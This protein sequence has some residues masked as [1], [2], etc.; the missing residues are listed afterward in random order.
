MPRVDL[1]QRDERFRFL[2]VGA[3]NTVFGYLAYVAL[4]G[5]LKDELHY[6]IVGLLSHAIS[7]ANAFTCYRLLVFRSQGKLIADFFRFN[8]SQ[9]AVVGIGLVG[10]WCLVDWLDVTPLFA[11]ALVTTFVVVLN[12][13]AHRHFTFAK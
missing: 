7:T 2:V 13:L 3:C 1:W 4:Y 12:Y 6:L 5:L 9:L 8:L 10:L 11:Q